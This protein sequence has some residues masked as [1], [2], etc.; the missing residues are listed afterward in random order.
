[1]PDHGDMTIIGDDCVMPA[2]WKGNIILHQDR[3]AAC[4]AD[5]VL[6]IEVRDLS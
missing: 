1:M 5:Q 4:P 6:A 3:I 2:G